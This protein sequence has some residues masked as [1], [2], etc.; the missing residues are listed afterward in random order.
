MKLQLPINWKVFGEG[1]KVFTLAEFIEA[2]S[3]GVR[4]VN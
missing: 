2:K 4:S 1:A 3:A